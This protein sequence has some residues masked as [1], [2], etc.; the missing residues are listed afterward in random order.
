MLVGEAME[1]GNWNQVL[2]LGAALGLGLVLL[3]L[4][5]RRL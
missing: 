2:L 4:I 5:R 1:N 3:M